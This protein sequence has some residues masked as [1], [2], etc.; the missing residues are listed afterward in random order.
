M[1]LQLLGCASGIMFYLR[2]KY[3]SN[4]PNMKLI[5]SV[6]PEYV[7]TAYVPDDWEVPRKK[8]ELLREL[9]QGSFGMVYEGI[10]RDVVKG[11]PEIRCAIKTVNEH[12]TDRLVYV[13]CNFFSLFVS[14]YCNVE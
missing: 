11:K 8:I 5:A 13:V 7:S 6:N 3:M 10:A 12:A 9:G 14:I 4:V 2:R 1:Y